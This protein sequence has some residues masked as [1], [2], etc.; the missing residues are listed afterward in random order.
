VRYQW[1]VFI[2]I[3][4]VAGFLLAHGASA[5]ITFTLHHEREPARV[6]ALLQLSGATMSAFYASLALL[7]VGGVGAGFAGRWWSQAWIW[8]SLAVLVAVT[9]AMF[10]MARTYYE[11]IRRVMRIHASGSSAVGPEE[12]ERVLAS[13]NP[14][15][16]AGIG[17]G[18]L[19]VILYLM[20]MKPF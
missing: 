17:L 12:I 8:A 6:D 3:V 2:H 11:R 13:G 4:G 15:L 9:A 14:L 10:A 16:I 18:G 20:V 7:L 1:W 19:L 5:A